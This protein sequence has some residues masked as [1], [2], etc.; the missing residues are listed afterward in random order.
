MY[1]FPPFRLPQFSLP[2]YIQFPSLVYPIPFPGISN[3]LPHGNYGRKLQGTSRVRR[4]EWVCCNL[5]ASSCISPIYH[6]HPLLSLSFFLSVILSFFLSFV[7]SFSLF[8]SDLVWNLK[9]RFPSLDTRKCCSDNF[10]FQD[11]ELGIC[12]IWRWYPM[13]WSW[14]FVLVWNVRITTHNQR[15]WFS[16]PHIRSTFLLLRPKWSR[17][18]FAPWQSSNGSSSYDMWFERMNV[19][20][21]LTRTGWWMDW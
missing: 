5:R 14:F 12:E 19:I 2:W 20:E 18:P 3:S 4:R 21:L 1:L 7:L 15:F 8:L 16:L 9:Q 10:H 17:S 6:F 11:P 13:I